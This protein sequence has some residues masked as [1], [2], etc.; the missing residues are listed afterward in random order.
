MKK[1]III[2]MFLTIA[3]IGS[4]SVVMFFNYQSEVLVQNSKKELLEKEQ[5][6]NQKIADDKKLLLDTAIA[7]ASKNRSISWEANKDK[8]GVVN[9]YTREWI[10][11]RYNKDIELAIE[12]YK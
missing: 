4:V 11:E 10:D 2:G 1:Y 12:R 3:I 9:S 5:K 6:Y 7:Q 8:N